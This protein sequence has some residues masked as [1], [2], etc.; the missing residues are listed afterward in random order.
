MNLNVVRSPIGKK[1]KLGVE[2]HRGDIVE[3]FVDGSSGSAVQLDT[4][5]DTQRQVDV[6]AE[7][8]GCD[9]FICDMG[10]GA[11][12]FRYSDGCRVI[13]NVDTNP[14]LVPWWPRVRD[15]AVYT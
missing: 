4:G 12:A 2:I 14:D 8:K 11:L 7:V 13:G 6:V 15:E 3:F 10:L 1:D 5:D 9:Y